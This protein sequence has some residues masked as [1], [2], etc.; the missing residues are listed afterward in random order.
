MSVAVASA[1]VVV[2][3]DSVSSVS[4]AIL[5][6][7]P[8]SSFSQPVSQPSQAKLLTDLYAKDLLF[9]TATAAALLV[10]LVLV[11]V[12]VVVVEV[13]ALKQKPAAKIA[14]DDDE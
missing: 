10:H 11:E 8:H 14:E 4:D 7:T 2:V 3:V 6:A 1:V 13:K 12:V 9:A 5:S